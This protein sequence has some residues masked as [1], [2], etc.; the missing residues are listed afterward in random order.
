MA[1][2]T[3]HIIKLCVGAESIE[4]LADWQARQVARNRKPQ[5]GAGCT[6]FMFTYT[7]EF[8]EKMRKRLIWDTDACILK[9]DHHLV[10]KHFCT[11]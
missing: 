6:S 5:P 2:M 10:I 3:V 11:K 1:F 9:N 8:L 7:I 4:D